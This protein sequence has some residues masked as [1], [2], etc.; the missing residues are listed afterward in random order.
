MESIQYCVFRSNGIFNAGLIRGVKM[1]LNYGIGK[2]GLCFF[3]TLVRLRD[4]VM[5]DRLIII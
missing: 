4:Y 3:L 2:G 1:E 5:P